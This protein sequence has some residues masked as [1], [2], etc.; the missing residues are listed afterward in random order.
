MPD[1][2]E[3]FEAFD[4][5][6]WPDLWP[7]IEARAREIQR[8]PTPRARR[9]YDARRLVPAAAAAVVGAIVATVLVLPRPQSALAV[10]EEGIRKFEH[11]PPFHAFLQGHVPAEQVAFYTR[12]EVRTESRYRY[13]VWY[14]SSEAWRLTLVDNS[15]PVIP[16][17]KPGFF[18]VRNGPALHTYDPEDN[19][20]ATASSP[21]LPPERLG[22]SPLGTLDWEKTG[23]KLRECSD[24]GGELELLP[25]ETVAGRDARHIRCSALRLEVWIDAETGLLLRQLQR[26]D[27]AELPPVPPG[28]RFLNPGDRFEV[29][30]V[31]YDPALPPGIFEFT[32]PEGARE[33]TLPE[34][35]PPPSPS[36]GAFE[37]TFL[38]R[39][40]TAPTWSGRLLDGGTLD[41]GGLRGRPVLVLFWSDTANCPDAIC[42]VSLR[43]FQRAFEEQK[44]RI[45]F[46]SVELDGSEDATR[47]VVAQGGYNFPVVFDP[48]DEIG[49]LW[50]RSPFFPVWVLL[51]AEGRVVDVREGVLTDRDLAALLS[52]ASG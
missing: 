3:R 45:H 50:F 17:G 24:A 23:D 31:E 9:R 40:Q 33:M 1:L 25:D 28:G 5:V 44:D 20:F 39:G 18:M 8:A 30:S 12:G 38:V 22:V 34:A 36:P 15:L 42:G 2:R 51:D 43:Q 32:P 29:A 49:R 46:V 6:R 47:K 48:T 21:P 27:P 35:S 37:N 4:D 19:T 11:V 10:V 13:E 16:P 41:I 14:R 26:V 52:E 7:A